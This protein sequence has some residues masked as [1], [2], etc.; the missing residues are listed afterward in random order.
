[1][2][3]QYFIISQYFSHDF[4]SKPQIFMNLLYSSVILSSILISGLQTS[5]A[6]DPFQTEA[7]PNSH[8][9]S[10]IDAQLD[11]RIKKIKKLPRFGRTIEELKLLWKKPTPIG[12]GPLIW[13]SCNGLRREDRPLI[14]KNYTREEFL[15]PPIKIQLF[16]KKNQ[17]MGFAFNCSNGGRLSIEQIKKIVD[18]LIGKTSWITYP[19]KTNRSFTQ[20]SPN[21]QFIVQ[22]YNDSGWVSVIDRD[23]VWRSLK[24]EIPS[25][26]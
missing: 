8:S 6:Q 4:I 17:I 3:D 16:H 13:H 7:I 24:P 11:V 18:T 14:R 2:P 21:L 26:L 25:H 22:Y 23:A 9:K 10:K 1:M 12:Q 15:L 20:Y 5:L 19:V